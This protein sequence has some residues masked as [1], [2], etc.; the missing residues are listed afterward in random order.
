M[1]KSKPD[2]LRD[3]LLETV[4]ASLE[5]Q[6]RAVRRL[7]KGQSVSADPPRA[8]GRSQIDLIADILARA[9]HEMHIND[10]LAEVRRVHQVDLDR[11][12][13]VSALTKKIQRGV[14]FV[15]TAPNMFDLKK[16]E[17]R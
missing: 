17:P 7:R 5:A 12:S 11:E 16:G 2:P 9:G 4:E 15:R 10:L 6:L 13:V 3:A 14:R 8:R 1:S